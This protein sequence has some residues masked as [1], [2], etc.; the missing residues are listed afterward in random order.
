MVSTRHAQ[1]R[2][3]HRRLSAC[4]NSMCSCHPTCWRKHF[5]Q[6]TSSGDYDTTA[7]CQNMLAAPKRVLY[8]LPTLSVLSCLASSYLVCGQ[9]KGTPTSA[10]LALPHSPTVTQCHGHKHHEKADPRPS[11]RLRPKVSS[12][13]FAWEQ[14]NRYTESA[15]ASCVQEGLH[16]RNRLLFMFI[17]TRARLVDDAVP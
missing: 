17:F 9:A 15:H 2:L 1:K 4:S 3:Q 11:L 10:S 12:R 14:P 6:A 13:G 16:G 5:N 8:T 7:V